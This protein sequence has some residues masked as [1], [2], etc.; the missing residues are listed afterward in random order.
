M[1]PFA[2]RVIVERYL[3]AGSFQHTVK[4]E[5]IF[6]DERLSWLTVQSVANL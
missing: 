1:R 2:G 5:L 6:I 4:M 3:N